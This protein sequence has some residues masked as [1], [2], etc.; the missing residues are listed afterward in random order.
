MT[1][2]E[3]Y[4]ALSD[5]IDSLSNGAYFTDMCVDAENC[6]HVNDDSEQF[7]VCMIYALHNSAGMRISEAGLNPS[8][9]GLNY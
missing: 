2:Y 5:H 4:Q 9:F 7:W 6:G 8:D 1:S 3:K